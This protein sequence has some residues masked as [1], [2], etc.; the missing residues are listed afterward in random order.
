MGLMTVFSAEQLKAA[1][2]SS[3]QAFFALA[4]PTLHGIQAVVDLNLHAVK[5]NITETE[6]TFKGALQSQNPVEFFAQQVTL[7]QQA[8]AKAVAYGQH[9][10]DIATKTQEEWT[11]AARAQVQQHEQQFKSLTAGLSHGMPT[12]P[13]AWIATMNSIFSATTGTTAEAMRNASR[14]AMEAAQ[15]G[16]GAF[17]QLARSAGQQGAAQPA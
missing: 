1:G 7:A 2:Q 16:F 11:A 8:T 17:A 10:V 15:G 9:L 5:A 14:Q 12:S 13:D 4:N 6:A 3:V